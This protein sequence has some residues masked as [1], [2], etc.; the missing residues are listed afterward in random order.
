MSNT[1]KVVAAIRNAITQ[2]TAN[3]ASAQPLLLCVMLLASISGGT[4]SGMLL[5]LAYTVR[6]ELQSAGSAG[7]VHGLN[8]TLTPRRDRSGQ[9]LAQRSGD[10]VN[11][12]ITVL[13][14]VTILANPC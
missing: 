2:V 7:A 9:G 11:S 5:D 14:G 6:H 8:S 4:G 3:P 12:T 13:W 1:T 10:A